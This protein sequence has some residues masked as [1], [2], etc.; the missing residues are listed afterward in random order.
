MIERR[1][2]APFFFCAPDPAD[3]RM[4][5]RWNLGGGIQACAEGAGRAKTSRHDEETAP[6]RGR[7]G[8]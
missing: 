3:L 7:V 4:T 6:P 8:G 2:G 1:L 5:L